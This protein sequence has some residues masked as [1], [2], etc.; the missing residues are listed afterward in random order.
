MAGRV[1]CNVL[2]PFLCRHDSK[3]LPPPIRNLGGHETVPDGRKSALEK[4]LRNWSWLIFWIYQ[5]LMSNR[6]FL[7]KVIVQ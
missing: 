6:V 7:R 1:L 4:A 3:D 5:W 2:L